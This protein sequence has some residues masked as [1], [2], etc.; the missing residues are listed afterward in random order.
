MNYAVCQHAGD[1]KDKNPKKETQN[2]E[3]E[4]EG[5]VAVT[6]ERVP[7]SEP[8]L[9]GNR[10]APLGCFWGCWRHC[11]HH[12]HDL[13]QGFPETTFRESKTILASIQHNRILFPSLTES[14]ASVPTCSVQ[15][16]SSFM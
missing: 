14:T 15:S 4:P 2:K 16:Q 8:L 7:V 11:S 10:E 13:P 6:M 3:A 1:P 5:R 12:L 9:Q